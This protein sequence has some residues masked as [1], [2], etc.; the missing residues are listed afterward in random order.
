[1]MRRFCMSGVSSASFTP[2][3]SAQRTDRRPANSVP[4]RQISRNR[5][6]Y[7]GTA[8]TRPTGSLSM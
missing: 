2:A 1:M 7:S 6:R 4:L 8:T 5:S 3:S